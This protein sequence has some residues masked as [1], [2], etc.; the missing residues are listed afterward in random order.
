MVYLGMLTIPLVRLIPCPT[1]MISPC[2]F[3][4][5]E[6][7]DARMRKSASLRLVSWG[8]DPSRPSVVKLQGFIQMPQVL[9]E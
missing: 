7:R 3:R 6:V 9:P 1:A 5:R 8:P 4:M 2:L